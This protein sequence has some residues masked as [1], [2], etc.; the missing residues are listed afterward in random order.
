MLGTN[1]SG[2][3]KRFELLI[4]GIFLITAA[5][6]FA[7]VWR[8]P[9]RGLLLFLPGLVLLGGAI[10]QDLQP[11]WHAGAFTYILATLLVGTGLAAI[12]YTVLGD[13]IFVPGWLWVVV[14]IA[15]LGAVLVA[16]A[17]YDPTLGRT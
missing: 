11:G 8:G 1:K 7:V 9:L 4:T 17:L 5:G 12:F 14:T 15:E 2:Q 6:T 16:K 13:V 3:E 10:F